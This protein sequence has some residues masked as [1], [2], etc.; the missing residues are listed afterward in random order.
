MVGMNIQKARSQW[1]QGD[2]WLT[3]E[4]NNIIVASAGANFFGSLKDNDSIMS[5]ALP[6][7]MVTH[8][9]KFLCDDILLETRLTEKLKYA[10]LKAHSSCSPVLHQMVT[11]EFMACTIGSTI[12]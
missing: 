12:C 11:S 5:S 1:R 9:A 7:F 2:G 6:T 10:L 8:E 4:Y 3:M